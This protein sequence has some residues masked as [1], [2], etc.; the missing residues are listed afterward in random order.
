MEK[1]DDKDQKIIEVLREDASLS[2]YQISKKANIPVTTVHNRLKKLKDT[3]VIKKYTIDIDFAKIGREIGAITFMSVDCAMLKKNKLDANTLAE[4]MSKHPYV[5][6]VFVPTGEHDIIM[7]IRCPSMSEL[8]KFL[9]GYL[10][11]LPGVS[12]THTA[13]LLAE[14]KH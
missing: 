11:S 4:K 7:E 14:W 1:L 2:T 6:H 5:E 10:R 9:F 8:N 13:P 3:G 12:M